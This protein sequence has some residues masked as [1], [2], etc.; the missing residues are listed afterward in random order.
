MLG[1]LKVVDSEKIKVCREIE[2]YDESQFVK[3]F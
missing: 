1:V 2:E 3:I